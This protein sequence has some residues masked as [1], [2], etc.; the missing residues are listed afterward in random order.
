MWAN[1][2][3]QIWQP[4]C[5]NI[6]FWQLF[7]FLMSC[8]C[9]NRNIFALPLFHNHALPTFVIVSSSGCKTSKKFEEA[10]CKIKW[11]QVN[12]TSICF[13]IFHNEVFFLMCFSVNHKSG[14]QLHLKRQQ[15]N[16]WGEAFCRNFM[17]HVPPFFSMNFSWIHLTQYVFNTFL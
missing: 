14:K 9:Y 4:G 13:Q 7:Q 15:T 17:I 2:N 3:I 10:K 12:A 5:T 11:V 16:F 6:N 1:C 8:Y